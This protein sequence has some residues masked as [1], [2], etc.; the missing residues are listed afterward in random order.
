MVS[1]IF[2]HSIEGVM[3]NCQSVWP[4]NCS[5]S[6]KQV[7]CVTLSSFWSH[8]CGNECIFTVWFSFP[9]V[10]KTVNLVPFQHKCSNSKGFY[11]PFPFFLILRRGTKYWNLQ[12]LTPVTE[13]VFWHE[14]MRFEDFSKSSSR[15][16][17]K[18]HSGTYCNGWADNTSLWPMFLAWPQACHLI[19]STSCG[20]STRLSPLPSICVHC[21][22]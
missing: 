8:I 14:K 3:F 12:I 19:P 22:C 5:L 18:T 13:T 1:L 4:L 16:Y 9:G 20:L 21:W 15:I 2:Y 17:C 7:S 10:S 6:R 11:W